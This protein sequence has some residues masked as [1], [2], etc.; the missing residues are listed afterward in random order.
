MTIEAEDISK[1][2]KLILAELQTAQD[3]ATLANNVKTSADDLINGWLIDA[4]IN[5]TQTNPVSQAEAVMIQD[6]INTLKGN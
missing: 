5:V 4:F 2:E 1:V 6:A 3:G